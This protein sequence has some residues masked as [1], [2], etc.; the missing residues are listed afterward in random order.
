MVAMPSRFCQMFTQL[1]VC[2]RC[3]LQ[4]GICTCLIQCNRVKACKHSNIRKDRCIILTVTITVWTDI[5]NQCDMEMRASMT[6]CLCIFC[7]LTV[8]QL[9]CTA[10]W[11]IDSIKAAGSNTSSATLTFI[12]IDHS[13]FVYICNCVTSTFFGTAMTSTTDFCIDCRLTTC[14]LLHLSCT[15]STTHTN[16]F[17]GTAKACCFM[18]LKMTQADKNICI[19]DCM[20]DQCGLAILTIHYRY[21]YFIRTSHAITDNDLASCCNRIKSI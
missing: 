19:H 20:S 3:C 16:I 14:M 9:V 4:T 11:I 13:F 7:H 17:K 1:T 6:D 21:F 12:I 10:V 18:S 2:N 8:K 15:A 5:L